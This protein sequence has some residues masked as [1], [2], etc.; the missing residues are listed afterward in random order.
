MSPQ[1]FTGTRVMGESRVRILLG[2][3]ATMVALDGEWELTTHRLFQ[4]QAATSSHTFN[5]FDL[6]SL[7]KRLP[8]GFQ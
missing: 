7:R 5:S 4:K 1:F 8:I 6:T 2:R 3:A